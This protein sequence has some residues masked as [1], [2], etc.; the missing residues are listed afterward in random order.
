M[1][2]KN[3]SKYPEALRF[4]REMFSNGYHNSPRI[5]RLVECIFNWTPTTPAWWTTAKANARALAKKVRL[6][7]P[8]LFAIIRKAKTREQLSPQQRQKFDTDKRAEEAAISNAWR[9]TVQPTYTR[10][11]L[12]AYIANTTKEW[13]LNAAGC[14]RWHC[15]TQKNAMFRGGFQYASGFTH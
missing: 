2:A 10:P 12:T 9:I 15:H 13:D 4:Q 7:I 1:I 5:M 8:D 3:F 11:S 6:A 14:Y